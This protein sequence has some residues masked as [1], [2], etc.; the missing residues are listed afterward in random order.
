MFL[1]Y[2]D[3]DPAFGGE[4]GVLRTL[5]P[6]AGE[7]PRAPSFAAVLAPPPSPWSARAGS[8]AG[9]GSWLLCALI[10]YGGFASS[11]PVRFHRLWSAGPPF[12]DVAQ[13]RA[14]HNAPPPGAL[15]KIRDVFC[16]MG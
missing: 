15:Y 13:G 8:A 6:S 16:P 11:D 10:V 1:R 12:A 4:N 2:Q 9:V 3:K 5:P 7:A 14:Q